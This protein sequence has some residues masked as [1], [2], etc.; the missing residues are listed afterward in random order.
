MTKKC[1]NCNCDCH[2]DGL[3]GDEYGLCTCENCDCNGREEDS[4]YEGGGV[5]IDDTGECESCQ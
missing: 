5:V 1:K 2:C 4:T 3:H